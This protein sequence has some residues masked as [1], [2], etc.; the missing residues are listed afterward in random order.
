MLL[1][2]RKIQKILLV[3]DSQHLRRAQQLFERVGFEVLAAPA[4]DLSHATR[5]SE[6]R[7]QL[8]RRTVGEVIAR[9][10]YRLAGYL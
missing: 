9:L 5:S 1:R 6:G 10:Y 2:P 8:T 7:L 3:T 4:D